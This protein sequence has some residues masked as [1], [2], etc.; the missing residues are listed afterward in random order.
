MDPSKLGLDRRSLDKDPFFVIEFC[1]E[2]RSQFSSLYKAG[3]RVFS[4]SVS[5]AASERVLSLLKKIFIAD[6]VSLSESILR[7]D[8]VVPSLSSYHDKYVISFYFTLEPKKVQ[9]PFFHLKNK[10]SPRITSF[11]NDAV[12]DSNR[13]FL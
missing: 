13:I 7:D 2:R 10:V 1:Q 4:T 6:R 5:S 3:A 9:R 8:I 11:I 12:C